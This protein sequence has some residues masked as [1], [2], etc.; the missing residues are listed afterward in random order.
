MPCSSDGTKAAAASFVSLF[1]FLK[2]SISPAATR[3]GRWSASA[4]S[5]YSY[6]I[7]AAG[8]NAAGALGVSLSAP[9]FSLRFPR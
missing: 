6:P 9:P 2:K 1:S 8:R 4:A 5:A 7:A 3:R